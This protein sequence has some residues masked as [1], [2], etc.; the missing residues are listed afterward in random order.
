MPPSDPSVTLLTRAY[1]FAAA[2]HM[3]QM[4]NAATGEPYLHHPIEV[5]NLLAYATEG[6]NPVLVAA[7]VLH[8][9]LEDT[10]T[11]AAELRA[12]FGHEVA[13]LVGEVTDPKGLA[14]HERRMR[15]I[16]HVRELS[17]DARL[18]KIAD[19]TSNIRERLANRPQGQSDGEIMDYVEWG[20]MVVAGCRG[21]NPRLDE[22]FDA[23]CEAALKKFGR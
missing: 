15:Q 18:L 4:R 17:M 3:G 23:A 6:A 14:E 10:D 20:A 2:K 21:L 1:A 12:V 16:E 13:S 19:K 7:G 11:T 9:V 22:V 5:A 8:D